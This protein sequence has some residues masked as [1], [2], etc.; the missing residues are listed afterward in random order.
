MIMN[1][2]FRKTCMTVIF[3]FVLGLFHVVAI[4]S[5]VSGSEENHAREQREHEDEGHEEEGHEEEGHEDEGHEEDEHGHSG[6]AAHDDEHEEKLELTEKQ[7]KEI[8]LTMQKAGSASLRW[9]TSISRDEF[10]D[11]TDWL[12]LEHRKISRLV[13]GETEVQIERKSKLPG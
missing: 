1:N 7:K 10:E 12:I 11:L 2:S 6:E 8:G 13:A 3:F 9:P 4:P 5:G